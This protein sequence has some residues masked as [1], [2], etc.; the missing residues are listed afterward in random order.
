MAAIC[1]SPV[2]GLRC[3]GLSHIQEAITLIPVGLEVVFSLGLIFAGRDAGSLRY[4]LAAEGPAF[5][6]LSVFS[7]LGHV[8]P[9]FEDNLTPFKALDIVISATSFVPILLYTAFLYFFNRR[10]SFP[11][12][13]KR[14]A[15]VSKAF[16]FAVIPIIVVTNEIG[17]FIGIKYR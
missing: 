11:R 13:S 9:V 16:L 15:L 1:L 7:F 2:L 12:L 4:L 8:V 6:L 14:F 17:S 10:E 5:V 3:L